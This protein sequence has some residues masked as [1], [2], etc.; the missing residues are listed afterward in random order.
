MGEE[1]VLG[2]ERVRRDP[3]H[4][5]AGPGYGA[6]MRRLAWSMLVALLGAVVGCFTASDGSPD[7]LGLIGAAVAWTLGCWALWS[8]AARPALSGPPPESRW[9]MLLRW[10][11][12]ASA[13]GALLWPAALEGAARVPAYFEPLTARRLHDAAAVL[14]WAAGIGSAAFSLYV[15]SVALQTSRRVVPLLAVVLAA[16]AAAALAVLEDARPAQ[17]GPFNF[18]QR[19]GFTYLPVAG[20]VRHELRLVTRLPEWVADTLA[21]RSQFTFP[22]SLR[23]APVVVLTGSVPFLVWAAFAFAWTARCWEL[24][25]LHRAAESDGGG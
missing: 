6:W 12:R 10:V 16:A 15:G 4:A 18:H 5:A 21:G 17:F 23:A 14:A 20:P 9:V 22:P 2:Y 3:W 25:R 24:D 7:A 13:V 8:A 11:M 1:L 19:A